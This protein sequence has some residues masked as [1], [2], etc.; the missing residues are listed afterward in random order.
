MPADIKALVVR[1]SDTVETVMRS[2]DRSG[3]IGLRC[4]WTTTGV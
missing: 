4:S 2:I 3:R 1:Q